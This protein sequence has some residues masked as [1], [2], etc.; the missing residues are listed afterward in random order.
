MASNPLPDK[1]NLL[2]TEAEDMSDGL[3][4]HET[5]LGVKQNTEAVI[6]AALA[7]ARAA[8]SEFGIARDA[9]S[10]A[11][12]AL[13]VTDSNAREFI[14]VARSLLVPRLGAQWSAAWL[15]TGFPNQSTTVPKLQSERL[16][17]CAALKTYFTNNPTLEVTSVSITVTA[18][19]AQA[20]FDAVSGA[21]DVFQNA[22]TISGQ[23]KAARDAAVNILKL[24]MRALI[25]ELVPLM[26]ADDPRWHG[27][28][29]NKPSETDAP[30]APAALTLT[31]GAATKLLADWAD[32]RR[33]VRYHVYVQIIG[34]DAEPR[35]VDTVNDS[36]ATLPGLPSGSTVAVSVTA[37]NADGDESQPCTAVQAVVP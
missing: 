22:T 19:L 33:A 36:D 18:A 11:N 3:H 5:P 26:P 12:E 32:A 15:P 7:A 4:R 21:R 6:R 27:F 23:K 31:P 16:D 30:D 17:L 8:E 37:L 10:D 20:R 25:E 9:K 14:G 34:V 29:L 35:R 1:L 24:R 2:F 28:G 13:R